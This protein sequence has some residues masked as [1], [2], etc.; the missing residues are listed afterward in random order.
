MWELT[1]VVAYVRLFVRQ[2]DNKGTH[3][4][5]HKHAS[6]FKT[7]DR[8]PSNSYL[9]RFLVVRILFALNRLAEK[10]QSTLEVMGCV[11]SGNSKDKYLNTKKSPDGVEKGTD[12]RLHETTMPKMVR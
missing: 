1:V 11:S 4:G 10:Q 3:T 5:Q 8:F 6:R 7:S 12:R 9:R 2:A